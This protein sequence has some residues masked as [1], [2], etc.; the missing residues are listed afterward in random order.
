MKN[1]LIIVA[2]LLVPSLAYADQPASEPYVPP[3][4]KP[5]AKVATTPV[6]PTQLRGR[7]QIKAIQYE[8][9]EVELPVALGLAFRFDARHQWAME[10][11]SGEKV[12]RISGTWS[13]K[14]A[15]LTLAFQGESI[16]LHPAT[17]KGRLHLEFEELAGYV[18]IAERPKAQPSDRVRSTKNGTPSAKQR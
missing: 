12:E 11:R 2:L 8:G 16:V 6:G 5:V 1:I 14:G 9:M 3:S 17:A 10:F 13:M 15:A 4:I 18:M 7:W